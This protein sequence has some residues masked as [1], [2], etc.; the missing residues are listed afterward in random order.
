MSINNN[1]VYSLKSFSNIYGVNSK[2]VKSLCQKFGLN[3]FNKNIKLKKKNNA[4]VIKNFK[5]EEYDKNLKL[6]I[7][8]N[9]KFLNQIRTYRGIRHN[10]KLPVRGQRTKTNAKTKKR[11]KI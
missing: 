1:K 10:L 2:K 4:F 9:I 5:V 3:P 6:Q 7:R 11:F 8:K